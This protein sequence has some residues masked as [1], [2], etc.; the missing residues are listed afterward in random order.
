MIELNIIGRIGQ[1]A[2]KKFVDGKTVISFSVAYSSVFKKKDESI[3]D[4]W[5]SCSYWTESKIFDYL[6]KGTLVYVSGR[7]NF[8]AYRKDNNELDVHFNLNIE[9]CELLATPKSSD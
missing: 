7:P 9:T 1:D 5:V 6:K 4:S 2:V 3:P 8:K